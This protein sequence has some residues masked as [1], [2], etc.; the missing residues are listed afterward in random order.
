MD[1]DPI[2][3]VQFGSD[4][5]VMLSILKKRKNIN[6]FREKTNFVENLFKNYK[7]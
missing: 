1:P 2:I 5:R 3:F 6:S 4:S 7:K